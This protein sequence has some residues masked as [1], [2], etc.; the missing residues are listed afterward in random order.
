MSDKTYK[1]WGLSYSDGSTMV[2]SGRTKTEARKASGKTPRTIEQV[3]VV[4]D[5]GEWVYTNRMHSNKND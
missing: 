3:G 4:T 5:K 1:L 2:V